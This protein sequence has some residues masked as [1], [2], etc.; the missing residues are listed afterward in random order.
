MA[1]F[2]FFDEAEGRNWCAYRGL[3]GYRRTK[4]VPQARRAR[5]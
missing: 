1:W 3:A 2:H 5:C 4:A